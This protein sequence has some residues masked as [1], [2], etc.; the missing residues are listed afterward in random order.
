MNHSEKKMRNQIDIALKKANF[1][2]MHSCIMYSWYYQ[3]GDTSI[4]KQIM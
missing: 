1:G 2:I 4:R 3:N